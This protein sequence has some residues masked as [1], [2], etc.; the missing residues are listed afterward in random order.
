[1]GVHL[2]ARQHIRWDWRRHLFRHRPGRVCEMGL[3]L[4]SHT[5]MKLRELI[6]TILAIV[7]IAGLGFLLVTIV[8][9]R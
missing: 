2:V 8:I 3:E 4:G 5:K 7:T 9:K 6:W 1:M